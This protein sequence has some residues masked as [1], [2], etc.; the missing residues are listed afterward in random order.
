M[1]GCWEIRA[2]LSLLGQ[3][4]T[5]PALLL[6]ESKKHT[7]S[8]QRMRESR[9]Q[10]LSLQLLNLFQISATARRWV[11]GGGSGHEETLVTLN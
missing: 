11:R 5:A 2:I 9:S 7:P 4:V 3:V 6:W 1:M 10:N 8:T